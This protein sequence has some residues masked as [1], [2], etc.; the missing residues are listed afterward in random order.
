MFFPCALLSAHNARCPALQV[1]LN[2][3]VPIQPSRPSS[4]DPSLRK[5]SLCPPSFSGISNGSVLCSPSS[6]P[7]FFLLL[8]VLTGLRPPQQGDRVLRSQRG[9]QAEANEQLEGSGLSTQSLAY[10]SI[11]PQVL[12]CRKGTYPYRQPSAAPNAPV[13]KCLCKGLSP[14]P[15]PLPV[16]GAGGLQTQR[17]CPAWERSP[18]R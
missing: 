11:S 4:N 2:Q 14:S 10:D 5:P 13:G 18:L 15:H 1:V 6:V 9:P 12:T 7:N 3:A 17:V 16:P 8:S